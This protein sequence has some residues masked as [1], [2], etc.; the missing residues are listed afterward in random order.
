MAVSRACLRA[1]P[2]VVRF[3][4]HRLLATWQACYR[5]G[6]V[7]HL[8]E[9]PQRLEGREVRKYEPAN[10]GQINLRGLRGKTIRLVPVRPLQAAGQCAPWQM[11]AWLNL[12]KC[13]FLSN[14]SA[15]GPPVAVGRFGGQQPSRNGEA[16]Q[17]IEFGARGLAI[18]LKG[19]MGMFY[20]C[21]SASQCDGKG[22]T[23][24][25]ML[26]RRIAQARPRVSAARRVKCPG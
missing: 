7:C 23:A 25:S 5:N 4:S 20:S 19:S 9:A 6:P 18:P 15:Q 3:P 1:S 26:L 13:A 22:E 2:R 12:A 14:L 17:R 16:N 10:G 8:G 21:R 11:R 24:R